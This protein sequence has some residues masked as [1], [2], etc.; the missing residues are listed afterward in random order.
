VIR[1]ATCPKPAY[2]SIQLRVK[3]GSADL[4]T[5][6][7]KYANGDIDRLKVAANIRQG[8]KTRWI[9]LKGNRRCLRE[10]AVLGKTENASARKARIDFWGRY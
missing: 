5:L 3:Q 6:L 10:I 4:K 2:K 1:L 8:G 9:D 7:V